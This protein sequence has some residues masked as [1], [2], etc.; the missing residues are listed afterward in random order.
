VTTILRSLRAEWKCHGLPDR[1]SPA[2]SSSG[3]CSG[4][5]TVR[6]ISSFRSDS[7]PTSSQDTF[8][9]LGASIASEYASCIVSAHRTE[10][11]CYE[12]D[13]HS[14]NV[15]E[16]TTRSVQPTP[17]KCTMICGRESKKEHIRKMSYCDC[18]SITKMPQVSM[19]AR[20]TVCVCVKHICVGV[21]SVTVFAFSSLCNHYIIQHLNY[22]T[23]HLA[24]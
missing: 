3:C 20:I 6:I 17:N 4:N 14:I 16:T 15:H 12:Y 13:L 21:D 1:L 18:T 10:N 19:K 23:V 24:G 5:V 8:G 7:P 2:A 9:I 22:Q 11:V